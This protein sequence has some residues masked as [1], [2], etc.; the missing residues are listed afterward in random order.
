MSGLSLEEMI[1]GGRIGGR[2]IVK[3]RKVSIDET[4]A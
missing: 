2:L 4:K 3:H 1:I